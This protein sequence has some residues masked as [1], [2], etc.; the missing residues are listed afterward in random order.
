MYCSPDQHSAGDSEIIMLSC[1]ALIN[2]PAIA[3][4]G[5]E[6]FKLAVC[7]AALWTVDKAHLTGVKLGE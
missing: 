5:L 4:F 7:A 3:Q 1:S 2:D 6:R